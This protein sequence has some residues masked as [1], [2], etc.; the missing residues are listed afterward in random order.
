MTM[1]FGGSESAGET[2]FDSHFTVPGVVFFASAGDSGNG[3]EY[4][5]A[6]PYV[7]GVGGTTLSVSNT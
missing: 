3:A 6:S 7:V 4:P 2:Q 1:S 5:A